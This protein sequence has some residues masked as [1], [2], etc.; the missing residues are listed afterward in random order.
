MAVFVVPFTGRRGDLP[1][2]LDQPISRRTFVL[3]SGA[4]MTGGL[5]LTYQLGTR[6]P[7]V[8]TSPTEHSVPPKGPPGTLNVYV[9]VS[10]DDRVTLTVPEVELG[11]GVSVALAQI[12]ADELR[13]RWDQVIV[14]APPVGDPV[15][16]EIA[17]HGSRSIRDNEASLRGMA[18]L[19]RQLL[20]QEAAAVWGVVALQCEA[21]E[22]RIHH[23][24]S[25][26]SVP[27]GAVAEGAS[28]QR[29]PRAPMLLRPSQRTLAGTDVATPNATDPLRGRTKYG[30]D[31]RVDDMRYAQVARP[32]WFGAQLE[33]WDGTAARSVPGVID[34]VRSPFGIAVIAEHTWAAETGRRALD[35]TWSRP[36]GE[37]IDDA[38]VIERLRTASKSG[39]VVV[40]SGNLRS[41]SRSSR[42]FTADYSVPFL[43]HGALEPLSCTAHYRR[44]EIDVW[45]GCQNPS[46]V[47]AAV[48]AQ[49]GLDPSRVTI[50]PA[51]VGGSFG[52][53]TTVEEAVEAVALSKTV[54]RPVQVVWARSDD[55]RGGGYRTAAFHRLQASLDRRGRP[56]AWSQAVASVAGR[57]PGWPPDFDLPYGI[58]HRRISHA[59]VSLP[60][61]TGPWRSGAHS[62]L[63]F[64]I[65]GFID[66]LARRAGTDPVAYRRSLLQ[67]Q[68]RH[69][70]VLDAAAKAAGYGRRLGKGRAH[71][72]ALYGFAGSVV[73]QVAEVSR[74]RGRP[75]VHRVTCA[76]DCGRAIN[77]DGVRA[78]I[79][80]GIVFG[81]SA[82]LYGRIR[83][84][85]SGVQESNFHD[86]RLLRLRDAPDTM[87]EI[88][89]S[90]APVG[91]VGELGVPPVAPAVANAMLKLTGRPLRTLPLT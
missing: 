29:P 58:D 49:A 57:G 21:R 17:T 18:A 75:Q 60:V 25:N 54:G 36:N 27:F 6:L 56:V 16:G 39:Q 28:H 74:K 90:S 10:P 73:A 51:A 47:R 67:T 77:P 81:L 13:A 22:G 42:T 20:L 24:D 46:Q 63:A 76:I 84:R 64:A 86:Y 82:A 35:V 65:E 12:L 85:A 26:R 15:H 55:F 19:A 3:G 88:V 72:V 38:D 40:A 1:V 4:A 37:R 48:A 31:V 33:R 70:Q 52:R 83:L 32:P 71:G 14:R 44:N 9:H 30:L 89:S 91:G 23:R 66:E 43:A 2:S 80:G 50:H 34:V 59:A 69:L 11:Q 45:I 7:P 62:H 53:R 8:V 5:M 61:T 87:V 41:V 68:P 79:E 78:Q